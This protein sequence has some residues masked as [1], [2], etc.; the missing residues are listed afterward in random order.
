MSTP[1]SE[2][3]GIYTTS[4]TN[5][6]GVTFASRGREPT[7][8]G[9]VSSS[10]PEGVTFALPMGVDHRTDA[11]ERAIH[12]GNRKL[13]MSPRWGLVTVVDASDR[14]FAPTAIECHPVGVW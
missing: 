11:V 7:D 14:G 9:R 5:P 13:V 12:G 8:I 2:A 10:N 4:S 1:M 6:E 3:I